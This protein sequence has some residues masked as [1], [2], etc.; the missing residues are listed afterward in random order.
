MEELLLIPH[1]FQ[2]HFVLSILRDIA[3]VPPLMKEVLGNQKDTDI[4]VIFAF[5]K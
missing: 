1:V 2:Y 5:R 4:P 3:A